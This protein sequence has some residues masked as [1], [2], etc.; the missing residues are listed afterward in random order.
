LNPTTLPADLF[1]VVVCRVCAVHGDNGTLWQVWLQ[2]GAMVL[3]LVGFLRAERDLAEERSQ[4]LLP[5]STMSSAPSS[6][7]SSFASEASF[8]F[9]NADMPQVWSAP[10]TSLPLTVS[11]AFRGVSV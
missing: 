7:K 10:R 11:V 5:G 2:S 9:S 3:A 1:I 8:G 4:L 6:R